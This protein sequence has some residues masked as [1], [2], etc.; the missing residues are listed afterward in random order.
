MTRALKRVA[1]GV[2]F[3]AE[4]G[5]AIQGSSNS[6]ERT[7]H[8]NFMGIFGFISNFDLYIKALIEKFG[9]ADSGTISYLSPNKCEEFVKIMKKKIL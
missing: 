6:F 4:R 5:L 3:V 8:E 7:D 1:A 2:K 9:A